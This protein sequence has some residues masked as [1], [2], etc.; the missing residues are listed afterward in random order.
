MI[1]KTYDGTLANGVAATGVEGLKTIVPICAISSWYDYDRS[2]GLPF[3]RATTRA[4][5]PARSP[6][7][8]PSRSTARAT[9]DRM[10]AKDGDET[11]AYAEFWA[12]RDHRQGPVPHVRNVTASVFV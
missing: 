7:T 4:A 8:G 10:A 6:T 2:Q 1:G 5:C 9:L 11:G 3:S 12:E